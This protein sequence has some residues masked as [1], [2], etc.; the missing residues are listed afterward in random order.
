MPFSLFLALRYLKPKRTFVSVITVMSIVGVAVGVAALVVVIAVMSGFEKEIKE[1]LIGF[2]PH[3]VL[4]PPDAEE[5]QHESFPRVSWRRVKEEASKLPFVTNVAPFVEADVLYARS[6]KQG[7]TLSRPG[8]LLAIDEQDRGLMAKY[9]KLLTEGEF[10]FSND[11]MVINQDVAEHLGLSVGDQIDVISANVAQKAL[12]R[13]EE[14]DSLGEEEKEK[15]TKEIID[16]LAESVTPLTLRVSGIFTSLQHP[17]YAFA[18]LHIGR[19][20]EELGDDVGG[21]A[22]DTVDAYRAGEFT[23]RLLDE[24]VVPAGW[25]VR[26]WMDK[27]ER[28]FATIRNERM[29]MYLVLFMIVL[30][31]AFSIMNT[32]ITVTVQK[33]REIGIISALGAQMRQIITLFL[34]QGM[35]VGVVGVV[36]G[37]LLG[38]FTLWKRN[39]I[40]VWWGKLFGQELFPKEFYFLA[41][42]P[43]NLRWQDVVIISLGAFVLSTLAALPPAWMAARLDPGKALRSE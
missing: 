31:A 14:W 9:A 2:E 38:W 29:M 20:L 27:W 4:I 24:G 5:V 36:A 34:A 11:G 3:V 35:I 30:V 41:E 17:F 7:G 33:R 6:D 25:Y 22:L 21:L 37:N 40:K 12:R 1:S 32:L 26:P 39:T 28:W 42:I 16:D 23:H 8:R 10:D 18:P 13:L 19:E 43:A 15:R